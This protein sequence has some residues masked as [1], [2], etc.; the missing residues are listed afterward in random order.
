MNA[1]EVAALELFIEKAEVD[2]RETVEEIADLINEVAE[3]LPNH[4]ERG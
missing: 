2:F 1:E 3:K 4:R